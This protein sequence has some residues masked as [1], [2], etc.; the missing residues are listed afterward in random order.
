MRYKREILHYT[1]CEALEQ[2]AQRSYGCPF[3]GSVQ[4]QIGWGFEQPEL[5]EG[6][7]THSGEAGTRWSLRFFATQIILWFH[8]QVHTHGHDVSFQLLF[9][10]LNVH[11]FFQ[12]SPG[13]FSSPETALW[14]SFKLSLCVYNVLEVHTVG[15]EAGIRQ[16][17]GVTSPFLLHKS[18]VCL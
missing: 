17:Y 15:L 12:T 16:Y 6:A 18:T 4:G 5:V 10:N 11:E 13:L 9:Q 7:P 1:G 14:L 8:V 3:P 2:V